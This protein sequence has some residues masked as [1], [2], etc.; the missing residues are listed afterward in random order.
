MHRKDTMV[1]ELNLWSSKVN[2]FSLWKFVV[3]KIVTPPLFMSNTQK[4]RL[5][6]FLKRN[7]QK[8]D[9]VKRFINCKIND[10]EV[11]DK[12]SKRAEKQLIVLN[13]KSTIGKLNNNNRFQSGAF[14]SL[15]N[16]SL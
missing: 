7:F 11:Y 15:F 3:L 10:R 1:Y 12:V 13:R 6:I 8:N 14:G 16:C 9:I 2:C 5:A 4:V